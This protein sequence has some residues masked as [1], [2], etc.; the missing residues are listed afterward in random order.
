MTRFISIYAFASLVCIP[1]GI[2]SSATGLTI[3]VITSAI[4][5]YKSMISKKV[6]GGRNN[7]I[8]NKI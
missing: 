6:K 8:I 7:S 4:K 2:T 3:C 5:K 1:I